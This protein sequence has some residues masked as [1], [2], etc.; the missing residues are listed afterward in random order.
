MKNLI[1]KFNWIYFVSRRFSTVDKK[2]RSAVTSFL[3]VLGI[4]FGVM[5][6]TV[7]VSVMNGLQM[8][9]I[10][11]IM[12]ISSYH[13][14]VTPETQFDENA[15]LKTVSQIPEI[16]VVQRFYESQALV[17]GRRGKQQG[18]LI[19]SVSDDI[20]KTDAGFAKEV[21][22]INGDFDLTAPNSIVLG[23]S[24]AI[25]LGVAPGDNVTLLAMS[26]TSDVELIDDSRVFTVTGVFSCGYAD[27]NSTFAF[28]SDSAENNILGAKPKPIYGI[29][30]KNSNLDSRFIE[31]LSAKVP[32]AAF[33]SWRSYNR[34]F[35][36]ALRV[37][38]N[39]L[40]M[41][42]FI[43]FIVVGVNIFNGMRRLCYERREEICIFSAVGG[44]RTDIMMIF[45]IQ[46]ALTGFY[47]SFAGTVL[48]LLLSV[49][50]STIFILI[51]KISY[52]VQ[53]FF[54]SLFAP[55]SAIYVRQNMLYM[56][57]AQIPAQINF[58]ELFV[59]ALF[60]ILASLTA[61]MV[62]SRSILKLSCAE[63]LR[64]E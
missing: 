59:T 60:G 64:D 22:I 50:V 10:N 11:S 57:Y 31:I 36:G 3:A 30:L 32:D 16:S 52:Y 17:A 51:S 63:V 5:A 14:R 46:G 1:K 4:A 33:E 48:G 7:I 55:E 47:G 29:K 27:I 25:N 49:N 15:F 43:I 8:T 39:M 23:S 62:A 34:A 40:M 21:S 28:V 56:I 26:G 9:Y 53:Y 58:V 38:K 42:I 12:E 19:R 54:T 24:L 44:K 20:M 35:F 18:A 61:S 6:L 37:E 2:G 13:I 45:T 41:L